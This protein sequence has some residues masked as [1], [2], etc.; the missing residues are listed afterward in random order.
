MAANLH[1]AEDQMNS[2]DAAFCGAND[3]D[4]DDDDG[5][6]GNLF[7]GNVYTP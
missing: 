5:S 1:E 4:D 7:D 3:D 2:F 6:E